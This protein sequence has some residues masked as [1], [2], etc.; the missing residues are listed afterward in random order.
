MEVR[1]TSGPSRTA[2]APAARKASTSPS[3]TVDL[4]NAVREVAELEGLG[5]GYRLVF[6]TGANALQSVF[7][8]HGHVLGGRGL[9]WPP[10]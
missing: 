9:G 4:V 8:V 5:N 3:V 10:G 7:H 1:S 2:S 6:N